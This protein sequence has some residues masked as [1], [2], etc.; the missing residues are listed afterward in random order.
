MR[1][2]KLDGDE[3][4]RERENLREKKEVPFNEILEVKSMELDIY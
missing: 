3:V 2:K 4:E 1:L